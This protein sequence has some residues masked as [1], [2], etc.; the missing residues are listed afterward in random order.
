MATIETID[1]EDHVL[2]INKSLFNFE[3]IITY[4]NITDFLENSLSLKEKFGA[5][6][7]KV[8]NYYHELSGIFIQDIQKSYFEPTSGAEG[9]IESTNNA[10][11]VLQIPTHRYDFML[12]DEQGISLSRYLLLT[13]ESG[14]LWAVAASSR[15]DD[16][17]H[18]MLHDLKK[19]DKFSPDPLKLNYFRN[20]SLVERWE[21][22][23][24]TF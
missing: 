2:S 3:C 7:R 21:A 5:T 16:K 18:V 17:V 4:Q 15:L 8:F 12:E 20:L 14:G 6:Q 23:S 24:F 9:I 10:G 19:E 22:K 1:F 11:R 13:E